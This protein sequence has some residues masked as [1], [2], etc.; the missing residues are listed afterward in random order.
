MENVRSLPFVA[1]PTRTTPATAD[2]A[3]EI[4]RADVAF[5]VG[6]LAR[7]AM[8]EQL[9]RIATVEPLVRSEG[10]PDAVHDTRVA[11]RRLRETISLFRSALS[12]RALRFRQDLRWVASA[13]GKVRDLDV[14]REEIARSLERSPAEGR[15]GLAALD[16]LLAARREITYGQLLRTL[17]SRR[18][19][20]LIENLDT[21]VRRPP[22]ARNHAAALPAAV[23][24]PELIAKRYRSVRKRGRK[25]GRGASSDDLHTLRIR[26][27]R[28]RYALEVVTP[29][30]GEPADTLIKRLV[31][32]QDV[33]GD[34][35][36]AEVA[37]TTLEELGR[38][39][40]R[41]LPNEAVFAMG[42]LAERQHER[43]RDL[44]KRFPGAFAAI[45]G[46]RW[47]QLKRE[48]ERR[49]SAGAVRVT[50]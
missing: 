32:L 42:R 26:C 12:P 17:G 38:R 43:G 7:S 34:I 10:S 1:E 5:T 11:M 49:R 13:Y 50:G 22:A 48:M 47:K 14:Q 31:R 9:D 4:T 15:A 21:F 29:L 30:Y 28:L 27:K 37:I 25:L 24:M 18:Y 46:K 6:D 45:E 23:V 39:A 16:A 2:G 44:R 33:L 3:I 35:Q 36:D 19:A 41:R 20:H 8:R 40:G